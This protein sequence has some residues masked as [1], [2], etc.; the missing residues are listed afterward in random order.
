MKQLLG[1][2]IFVNVLAGHVYADGQ[3]WSINYPKA[4]DAT[5]LQMPVLYRLWVPPDV[6]E[7]RGVIVHQHGCGTGAS[8]NGLTAADDLH[9]QALAR[10]WD[11][12][13]LGPSYG[14][15]E[16]QKC[17]LWGD[18]RN[19]SA[20][21]FLRCLD[22]FAT[23]TNHPEL[24]SVPWCL[25]GHSGG[26]AWV[27]IMHALYPQ[28]VVAA[29][30]RS[31]TAF[32]RWSQGVLPPVDVSEEVYRVPLAL[33][34]GVRERGHQQFDGIAW[35][36]SLAMFNAYRKQNAP[37]CFAP[38][39][40][41]EHECGLSRLM[42]I[43]FLDECLRLRLPDRNGQPLK[44]ITDRDGPL[45]EAVIADFGPAFIEMDDQ[46]TA[47]NWF[48]SKA[49]KQ[50]WREYLTTGIVLDQS[51][52]PPPF[53]LTVE[54]EAGQVTLT[55]DA[56]A[57]LQS[58][59]RGFIIYRDGREIARMPMKEVQGYQGYAFQG[60]SYGDTPH[61]QLPPMSF[62][63]QLPDGSTFSYSVVA[64]NGSGLLSLPVH[65]P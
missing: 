35:T 18:P 61:P 17:H 47:P 40:N 8:Q 28:R 56:H 22:E 50:L 3:V 31:G 7:L 49:Y 19:G 48:P 32:V 36:G 58:G 15:E 65:A 26:G 33:N 45:L 16:D 54:V 41:T 23:I 13:L 38:D 55:W 1:Y 27:S 34:P 6:K 59:L 2:L 10:K 20:A 64:V 39:P 63:E 5:G 62:C 14:Q 44:P 43:P 46:L 4:S 12:A 52:P 11:C 25:W 24:R 51:P 21:A 42:A 30:C 53:N 37:V 57:D 9:W 29:W 60:I